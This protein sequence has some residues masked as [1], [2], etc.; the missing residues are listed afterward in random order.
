MPFDRPTL[1]ELTELTQADMEARLP[2]AEVRLR[3]SMLGV[4]SR[5]QAG[6]LH[7]VYG[8]VDY[9]AR[10]LFADTAEAEYLERWASIWGINRKAAGTAVGA[11]TFTGAVDSE[12]PSGLVLRRADGLEYVTTASGTIGPDG[13]IQVSAQ[14]AATGSDYNADPGIKLALAQAVT[15]VQSTGLASAGLTGGAEEEADDDLRSR[16]LTRLRQPPHGG[17]SF[18]YVSW[19]LEQPGVT[20]AW[21]SPRE[22]GPG[23]VTVRFMMDDTYADGIPQA[24][25]VDAVADDIEA[26]RPVTAEVYVVAPVP[27]PLD[28][29]IRVTPNTTEVRAAVAA[30]LADLLAREAEPGG[31]LLLSHLREAV[32]SAVGETDHAITAPTAD[33][34]HAP[35]EIPVLGNITWDGA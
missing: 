25:D 23:S 31:T 30:E 10:Q 26:H 16:L 9:L 19:A 1:P 21:C 34:L 15:G 2:G 14:A 22:M 18:D 8:Y 28:M 35:G 3:R 20:R 24:G 13:T 5:V 17:A 7:G 4:L 27:T 11:V 6:G 32:S 12:I 29:S 33:V